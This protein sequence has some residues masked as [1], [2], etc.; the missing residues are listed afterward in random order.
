MAPPLVSSSADGLSGDLSVGRSQTSLGPVGLV[1]GT[2]PP[3]FD[4]L[5]TVPSFRHTYHLDRAHPSRLT[6]QLGAKGVAD[7][8]SSAGIGVD[9]IGTEATASIDSAHFLLTDNPLSTLA[10]VGLSVSATSIKSSADASYVFG[11]DQGFL[12]GDASFGSL[13]ISGALVDGKTL[14]FSGDAAANTVLYKSAT[15]TITLDKQTLSD[16]F[17]PS[18][19]V[20]PISA[21]TAITPNVITTDALDIHFNNAPLFGTHVSGDIVLGQ[22]TARL[23]PSLPGA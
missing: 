22:T 11:S 2:A 21:A 1:G 4:D 14:T 10:I 13:S 19:V 20:P 12:G 15:V 16:F 17:P 8:A 5:Q 18:P 7:E 23:F 9:D 6:L 3:A